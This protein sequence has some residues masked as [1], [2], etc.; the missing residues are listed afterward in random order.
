[1][2]LSHRV[3]NQLCVV[4]IV[5][6]IKSNEIVDLEGQLK[7]V[8]EKH[9]IEGVILNL[10]QVEQLSSSGVA[11]ILMLHKALH[12]QKIKLGLCH[13]CPEPEELLSLSRVTKVIQIYSTEAEAIKELG[14]ERSNS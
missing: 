13:L 10:K 11:M 2:L 3:E 5:E 4:S 12:N 9:P 8:F 1:M 7:L 14:G 6:N